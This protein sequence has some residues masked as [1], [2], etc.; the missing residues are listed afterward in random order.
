VGR[1]AGE[2]A[3]DHR[4][5]AHAGTVAAEILRLAG[6]MPWP[7][8]HH[9]R[10][11]RVRARLY[12]ERD[13]YPSPLNYH[14]YPKS[15]CTSV[16]EVIC[17]GIPDSGRCGRRHR[18]PRRHRL[19]RRRARRHQRHVL[20]RRRRPGQP[21]AGAGHRGVH[22]ARHRGREARP[23]DQRHRRPSSSTPSSTA[24]AWCGRSSATA[25]ASS[26]TPTSRCPLLRPA[27]QH[28]HAAGHDVHD[29][30]DDHPRHV[31]APHVGRRLDAVTT[32]GKRTAQYEHTML[33]TDDGVDVLTGGEGAVSPAPWNR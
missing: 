23:S 19:H 9:R 28:H 6:E 15:V 20:R 10:A 13:A 32:D 2:V 5:H 4:A 31:A 30:A 12:I 26:S 33:V 29:R 17:H 8:S 22:V 27:G 24:T 7:G 14:G 21:R 25:S 3:R 18:E 16:N 1:A 11:R